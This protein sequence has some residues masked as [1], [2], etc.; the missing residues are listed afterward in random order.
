MSA[1]LPVC[2]LLVVPS[3]RPFP[4][5]GAQTLPST[6]VIHGAKAQEHSP[7]PTSHKDF[8]KMSPRALLFV[9]R[10]ISGKPRTTFCK[11]K[12]HL[13]LWS[14]KSSEET[15]LKYQRKTLMCCSGNLP[16]WGDFISP[17]A[18]ETSSV[19]DHCNQQRQL[20][21]QRGQQEPSMP[22]GTLSSS[23][24]G[25]LTTNKL[26]SWA[27]FHLCLWLRIFPGNCVPQPLPASIS[28]LWL[29]DHT[30]AAAATHPILLSWHSSCQCPAPPDSS[31]PDLLTVWPH[32]GSDLKWSR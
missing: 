3:L 2:T 14:N 24:P 25:L 32:L 26:W 29:Q 4:G 17:T 12:W 15:G 10:S 18:L 5:T 1:H 7:Q 16:W 11:N 28:L 6:D 20:P 31:N 8:V 23:F 19:L 22:K 30:T 9:K 13:L 27:F 21:E